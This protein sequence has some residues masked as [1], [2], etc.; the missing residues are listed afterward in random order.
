[1]ILLLSFASVLVFKQKTVLTFF[2]SLCNTEVQKARQVFG[3][4]NLAA[5]EPSLRDSPR[6]TTTCGSWI[7]ASKAESA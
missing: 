2:L 5:A 7:F 4:T 1:M 6:E 3:Q